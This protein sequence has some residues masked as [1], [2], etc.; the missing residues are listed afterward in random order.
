MTMEQLLKEYRKKELSSVTVGTT[1]RE[2]K[3]D[4]IENYVKT[5]PNNMTLA[6]FIRI[7]TYELMKKVGI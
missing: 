3:K 6:E 4:A 5:Q 1:I 7:G 2:D